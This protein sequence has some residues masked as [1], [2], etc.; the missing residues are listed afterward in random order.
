MVSKKQN[1]TSVL[2]DPRRAIM[3]VLKLQGAQPAAALAKRFG[4]TAMAVRQ[5]LYA[6]QEEGMVAAQS[7]PSGRGR[8]TKLWAL[9]AK[10]EGLF[11]DAHQELAVDLLSHMRAQFGEA[12]L[13]GIIDRHSTAQ[14]H[15]YEAA[16]A[17]HKT[18]EARVNALARLRND[19]GYMAAVKRDGKDWLLIE[20]HCPICAAARSCTRLCANELDV[21][22]QVL[23]PTAKVVREEHILAGA[24]RCA[25]RVS[26]TL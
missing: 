10:A 6:L 16:L 17:G 21:F 3:D 25:Y 2:R 4:V 18:L 15:S 13:A 11:P 23:G 22:T 1:Q 9:T 7:Q 5:H 20:N 8:P 14:R 26:P 19:E 12:G 24:R